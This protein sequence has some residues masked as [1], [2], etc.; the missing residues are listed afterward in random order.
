MA[1]GISTLTY[2]LTYISSELIA[3]FHSGGRCDRHRWLDDSYIQ[4][5]RMQAILADP[6]AGYRKCWHR[7][8]GFLRGIVLAIAQYK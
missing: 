8:W 3:N 6:F 5:D 2:L 7:M 1:P 4:R